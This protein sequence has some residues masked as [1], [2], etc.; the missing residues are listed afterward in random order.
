[1]RQGSFSYATSIKEWESHQI[2]LAEGTVAFE[3]DS[4]PQQIS[5]F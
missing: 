1:M 5:L 2:E 3:Y 4:A